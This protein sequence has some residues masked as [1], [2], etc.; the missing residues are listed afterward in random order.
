M[1]GLPVKSNAIDRGRVMV[2]S[3]LDL[4]NTELIELLLGVA[5]QDT[6]CRMQDPPACVVLK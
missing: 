5:R 3:L 1:V 4:E 2:F 6:R